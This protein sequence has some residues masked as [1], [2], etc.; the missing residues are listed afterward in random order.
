MVCYRR[1]GHNEGDDPSYTQPLMYKAHRR[2]AQRCAS[3]YVEALVK[4]GDSRSTRPRQT[5]D[6][7]QRRLQVALDETRQQRARAGTR[8]PSRRRRSGCCPHV[9]TGV[10]RADARRRSSTT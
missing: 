5:L 7:F 2:A 10:D 9:E 1:H 8:P 3:C 6:D 4:R